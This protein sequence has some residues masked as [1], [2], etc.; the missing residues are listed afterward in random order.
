MP[1]E[2]MNIIWLAAVV[3]FLVLEAVTYQLISIWFVFG[4]VGGLIASFFTDTSF[5][6]Q[7]GIFIGISVVLLAALRPISMKLMKR[8]DFKSNADSI[9]GRS[10]L[11]TQEVN[12]ASGTGQGKIDGMFWTVRALNDEIIKQGEMA[13]VKRIEGVKLVVESCSGGMEE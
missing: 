7:F 10:V 5:Y 3:V 6:V 12:N 13:E 1:I 11:I 2:T 4:A 9:I 8:Q